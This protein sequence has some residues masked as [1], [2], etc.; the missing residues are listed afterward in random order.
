VEDNKKALS[1]ISMSKR[2]GKLIMG[3]KAVKE[4]IENGKACLVVVTR[5]TSPK[6][7]KEVV[8]AAHK[9]SPVS[10]RMVNASQEEIGKAVGR[11]AGV[12]CILDPELSK[13]VERLTSPVTKEECR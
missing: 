7:I 9:E 13:A 5:D 3:F 8:F 10:V 4:N 1:M 11:K 6:T 2:A 12:L